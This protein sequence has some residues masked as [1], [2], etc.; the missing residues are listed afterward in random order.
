ML[1]ATGRAA[2]ATAVICLRALFSHPPLVRV[3]RVRLRVQLSDP[4]HTLLVHFFRCCRV[5]VCSPLSLLSGVLY[6]FF[7]FVCGHVGS[8]PY[9]VSRWCITVVHV[10]TSPVLRPTS[11]SYS[12]FLLVSLSLHLHLEHL[13]VQ[14]SIYIGVDAERTLPFLLRVVVCLACRRARG[15]LPSVVG[16]G[17]VGWGVGV[18]ACVCCVVVF[19]GTET[20]RVNTFLCVC[21][22]LCVCVRAPLAVLVAAEC[23]RSRAERVGW[24]RGRMLVVCLSLSAGPC[25]QSR[26]YVCRM[27]A[28]LAEFVCFGATALLPFHVLFVRILG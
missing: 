23:A 9:L 22:C 4:L 2:T 19:G 10:P 28:P 13:C 3:V 5:Y 21:M 25:M 20:T 1:A 14:L 18:C 12:L 7:C 11:S 27:C 16:V 8:P 17:T 6:V 24:G 26:C 15:L